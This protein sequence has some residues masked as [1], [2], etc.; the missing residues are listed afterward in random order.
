MWAL[1]EDYD[2]RSQELLDAMYRATS[3]RG[4]PPKAIRATLHLVS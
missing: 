1:D 4:T 3:S 2:G